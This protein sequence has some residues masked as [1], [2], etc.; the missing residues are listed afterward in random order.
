MQAIKDRLEEAR[1]KMRPTKGQQ[2]S[3]AWRKGMMTWQRG[4]NVLSAVSKL[5]APKTWYDWLQEQCERLAAVAVT[6]IE[7]SNYTLLSIK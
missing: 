1:N 6:Q 5:T 4:M 3:A 7:A 2:M